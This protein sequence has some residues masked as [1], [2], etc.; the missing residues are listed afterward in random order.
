MKTTTAALLMVILLADSL[1][2]Q[3]RAADTVRERTDAEVIWQQDAATR[4]EAAAH[5]RK[6]LHG[7]LTVAGAVQVA[8]LNNRH[9]RATFE[10][11]GIARADVIE[12]VTLP[13]P[14]VDFEI[15]FPVVASQFNR[16]GWLVAQ[17][18]AQ[19]LMIPLK[20][21]L[22][23]EQLE[24]AELRVAA[25]VLDLVAE[26][27]MAYFRVQAEQQLI[28]RLKVVQETNAAGLDL[29]QKQFEAGNL[30]DLELLQMQATYSE[31]RM[32]LA[33][34][35]TE[36]T[37]HREEFNRL[38]GLWGEQTA[39]EIRGDLLP[40]PADDFSPDHLEML[41]VSNRLDLRATHRDLASVVTAL[42]L[43]RTY[44]WIPVLDFG[45]T[46]ERDIEGALNM[47][48]A[49]RLELPI[50][51]QGQSRLARGESDLRRAEARFEA[52]AVDIRSE[53]RQYRD[54]LASLREQATFY[55]DE[56]L[57][58]RI[59]VVNR[60]VLQYNA[61]QIGPYA[62]FLAKA[63]ELEAER[64]YVDTLRDYWITRAQLEHA[65]GGS[66]TSRRPTGEG[67]KVVRTETEEP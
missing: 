12:A 38:L 63:E 30:T 43:T 42:G 19:I 60:S 10:D 64:G 8:V 44:R 6:Y 31:G 21:K 11:I 27:K 54:Q 51:N 40:P 59:Q 39:W 32:D 18:F 66:L 41:A 20:K 46:G 33:R 1:S 49:F 34:A 58:L 7:P 17:E 13:N 53:V 28:G 15:Q 4:D 29:S 45:F 14:S 16:Y 56:V 2:A 35:A 9:L 50:F 25:E 55:H 24:A 36:L 47:G 3:N 61:M 22:S 48:P 62:L 26:V 37:G 52:L 65:V 23:E 5:I 67:K 57:P